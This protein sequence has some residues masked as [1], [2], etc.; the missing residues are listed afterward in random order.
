MDILEFFYS[1]NTQWRVLSGMAT[2]Y[3]GLDYVAVKYIAD[4]VGF[5]LNELSLRKLQLIES[6][7]L[8]HLNKGSGDV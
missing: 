4:I 3:I 7:V 8:K 5:E 6:I 2:Q 1:I